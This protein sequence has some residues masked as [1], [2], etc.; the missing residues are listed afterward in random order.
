[1]TVPDCVVDP[2]VPVTV[3]MYV[4][5]SVPKFWKLWEALPHPYKPNP[6]PTKISA[7]ATNAAFPLFPARLRKPDPDNTS[8]K[9]PTHTAE[10]NKRF[11][12]ELL[13]RNEPPVVVDTMNVA[14]AGSAPGVTDEGLK[15]KELFAGSPVTESATVF[16]NGTL[17]KGVSVTV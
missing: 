12:S 4:P 1:M 6:Q 9:K 15:T 10:W 2:E 16:E 11:L 14:V 17:F 13:A 3:T 8:P 7:R 5:G